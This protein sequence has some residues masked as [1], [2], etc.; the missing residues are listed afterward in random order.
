ME[1][2]KRKTIGILGGMGAEATVDLYMGIWK[3]YQSN[4]SAKYDCE[5]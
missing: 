5:I 2:K 4:F 1:N 3:Y